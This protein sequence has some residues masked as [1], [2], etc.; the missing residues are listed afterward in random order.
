MV[1]MELRQ[2]LDLSNRDQLL[3]A[4]CVGL[5]VLCWRNTVLEDVHAGGER[6]GRNGDE[7]FERQAHQAHR[8]ELDANFNV[9][10]EVDPDEHARMQVLLEG[11]T[12]GFGIPDDVMMGAERQHG[13]HVRA[14]LDDTLPVSVTQVGTELAISARN[15]QIPLAEA[16]LTTAA[17]SS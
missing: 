12:Q 14:V 17:R 13:A 7:T 6:D 4:V 16:H 10:H 9:L 11:R 15:R 8:R 5:K 1:G 2:G 3:D